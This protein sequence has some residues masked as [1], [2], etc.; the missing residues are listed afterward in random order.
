[1]NKVILVG[2]LG[3]D[4][5]SKTVNE[6]HLS[7]FSVATKGYKDTTDWHNIE[8]WGKHAE[9]CGKYLKKGSTVAVEGRIKTDSYESNG[10]KK[11]ITKIVAESVQFLDKKSDEKSW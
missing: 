10:D 11:Y 3:K 9:A 2:N 4:P 8:V 7:T 5:E 6:S 1:M